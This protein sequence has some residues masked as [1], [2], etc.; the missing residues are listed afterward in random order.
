MGFFA[1][2]GFA[3]RARLH[4]CRVVQLRKKAEVSQN[5]FARR[6][7][8]SLS[9]VRLLDTSLSTQRDHPLRTRMVGGVGGD[10]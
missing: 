9:T 7:N 3:T 6:L 4:L 1:G 5:L 8:I 2:Q 10:G